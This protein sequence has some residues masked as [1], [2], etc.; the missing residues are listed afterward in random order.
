MQKSHKQKMYI[1]GVA[2]KYSISFSFCFVLLIMQSANKIV[3][4]LKLVDR[5]CVWVCEC[6]WR[7]QFWLVATKLIRRLLNIL[8]LLHLTLHFKYIC[9]FLLLCGF[10]SLALWPC[11]AA[12]R[13]RCHLVAFAY[14]F[15][16]VQLA[17]EFECELW[18][19]VLLLISFCFCFAYYFLLFGLQ[20]YIFAIGFRFSLLFFFCFF[21]LLH[22]I[23]TL[24]YFMLMYQGFSL[25]CI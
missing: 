20:F 23:I 21:K 17:F 3:T 2:V 19:I 8:L 14:R 16:P 4:S 1:D 24:L 12:N 22:I 25:S 5:L 7:L 9:L 18:N 15:E 6:I 13:W 11:S 10:R